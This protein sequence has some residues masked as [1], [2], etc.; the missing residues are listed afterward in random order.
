MLISEKKTGKI[1]ILVFLLLF[2]VGNPKRPRVLLQ[3]K[4]YLFLQRRR[5]PR[6]KC[7]SISWS[8]GL[9]A[10]TAKIKMIPQDCK[11][12]SWIKILFQ[13]RLEQWCSFDSAWDQQS[14]S[15]P[16]PYLAYRTLFLFFRFSSFA[17]KTFSPTTE[18]LNGQLI[19]V[20]RLFYDMIVCDPL[21]Q[22]GVSK[23][24]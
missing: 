2:L 13:H 14:V 18:C 21:W 5:T 24:P 17:Y 12:W 1:P 11:S 10:E 4:K 15:C 20:D 19:G 6:K 3:T 22:N 7:F 23:N 8:T 16:N 9:S